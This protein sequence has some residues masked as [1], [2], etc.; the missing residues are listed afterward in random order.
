VVLAEAVHQTWECPH[1]LSTSLKLFHPDGDLQW[2][3]T[4]VRRLKTPEFVRPPICPDGREHAPVPIGVVG[5]NGG[6]EYSR[7]LSLFTEINTIRIVPQRS[8]L[9]FSLEDFSPSQFPSPAM[10]HIYA[11]QT[12][13][14]KK[15]VRQAFLD[16][17]RNRTSP[18]EEIDKQLNALI[19]EHENRK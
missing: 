15:A 16:S 7:R 18:I 4:L 9:V 2:D 8:A 5:I 13:S 11:L 3:V 17:D 6:V 10:P 19:A 14:V 1:H 12:S